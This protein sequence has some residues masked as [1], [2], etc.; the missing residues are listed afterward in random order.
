M[1]SLDKNG[2]SPSIIP[3]HN[4][5]QCWL[6][7]CNGRGKMDRHE[8]FG[9]A[10]RTKSKRF[11]LWVHLCHDDCHLN[12]VHKSASAAEILKAEAQRIAMKEYGWSIDDF[13]REFGKNYI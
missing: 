8:V 12:G 6:C 1:S 11:G 13:I 3:Y 10:Y 5:T 9:G 4:P 2:Y 7:D